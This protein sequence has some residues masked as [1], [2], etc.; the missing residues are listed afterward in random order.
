MT[1]TM[2]HRI[3][4]VVAVAGI[5][6]F[7]AI[8]P[9]GAAAAN[10]ASDFGN[11]DP[12]KTGSITIHKHEQL[13][14]GAPIVSPDGSASVTSP[15]VKDVEFTVYTVNGIDLSTAAGWDKLQTLKPAADGNCDVPAPYTKTQV[16]KVT[17]DAAGAANVANLPVAAYLVCETNAPNTVVKKAA[18]FIVSV[19]HP[20]ESGWLY[21]VNV[22]PKNSLSA[23]EKKVETPTNFGIGTQLKF[24]VTTKVPVIAP[25]ENLTSFIVRDTLDS[26]LTPVSVAS[27]KVGGADVDPSYYSV[28]V[29]GQT[30][31]VTFTAAGL[32]WLKSQGGKSVE[33]VFAG[34]VTSIGD[35]TITNKAVAF[36]ND[37]DETDGKEIETNPVVTKWGDVRILKTDSAT[38]AHSLK[39]AEFEVYAAVTPYP[40]APGDCSTAVPTGSAVSSGGQT[41]FVSDGQG[42][43]AVPGLF[44]SDTNTGEQGFRCYVVKETK[45]PAGYVTPAAPANLT[46]IAVTVGQTQGFDVTVKNQQTPP[47]TLPLTGSAGQTTLIVIGVALLG[48]ATV[49]LLVRRKRADTQG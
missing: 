44:V 10:A 2:R 46:G 47:V 31:K 9:L 42:V 6:A 43:V 27:V 28:T 29:V 26:R 41:V 1:R 45:A 13:G 20:F 11:V 7:G 17:T 18:P 30:A 24:P 33:T 36:I 40:A 38:P 23:I 14:A 22:Y 12:A 8:G 19:P 48:A 25:S 15:G 16:A 34:V 37:P 21:D 49:L 32:D 5:A 3:G 4:R 39:G 35:G